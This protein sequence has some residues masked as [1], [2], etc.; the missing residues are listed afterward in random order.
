M[1]AEEI[2]ARCRQL[3]VDHAAWYN[4]ATRN[5]HP[6][7][8]IHGDLTKIVPENSFNPEGTFME[9]LMQIDGA[10]IMRNQWCN[11]HGHDCPILDGLQSDYDVSGL[12]CP[13]MSPAGLGLKEEGMTSTVFICHAKLHIAKQTPFLVVENVPDRVLKT[14]C[15]VSDHITL[16]FSLTCLNPNALISKNRHKH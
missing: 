13:D 4:S 5:W 10:S 14:T 8:C 6:T 1:R 3:I 7:P 16:V 15:T 11:T 2:D 12:P 9:R